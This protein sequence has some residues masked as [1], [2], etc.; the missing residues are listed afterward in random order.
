MR[1]KVLLNTRVVLAMID[2]HFL[3]NIKHK[4]SQ[5]D[6]NVIETYKVNL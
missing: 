5:I 2:H 4:S 6:E 1:K 3:Q